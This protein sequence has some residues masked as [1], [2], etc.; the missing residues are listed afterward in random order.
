VTFRMDSVVLAHSNTGFVAWLTR[1]NPL[2]TLLL[3]FALIVVTYWYARQNVRMA[4]AME[5]SNGIQLRQVEE[6][7]ASNVAAWI[8]QLTFPASGDVNATI[9][10]RNG[11]SVPIY[12]LDVQVNDAPFLRLNVLA[13]NSSENATKAV[14]R[15][16][17]DAAEL[18]VRTQFV[19]SKGA[20]WCREPNG[21]LKRLS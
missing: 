15:N 4:R 10:V 1:F 13:P 9:F 16:I 6:G 17:S 19:D 2:L 8:S 11:N 7:Q 12:A 20:C 3:T 5:V 21:E 14:D 18:R